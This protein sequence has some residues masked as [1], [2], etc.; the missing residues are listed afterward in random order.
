MCGVCG[1]WN[2]RGG[3]TCVGCEGVNVKFVR[4]GV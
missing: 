4:C 1:V 2:V 3:S